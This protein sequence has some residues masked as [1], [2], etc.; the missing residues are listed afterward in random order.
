[1]TTKTISVNFDKDNIETII[2]LC[3]KNGLEFTLELLTLLLKNYKKVISIVKRFNKDTYE[4]KSERLVIGSIPKDDDIEVKNKAYDINTKKG[5]MP[6][7]NNFASLSFDGENKNK[8]CSKGGRNTGDTNILTSIK[9]R[10]ANGEVKDGMIDGIPVVENVIDNVMYCDKCGTMLKTFGYKDSI[11]IDFKPATL[12]FIY[13]RIAIKKCEYCES[14]INVERDEI[15]DKSLVTINYKANLIETKFSLGTPIYRLNKVKSKY[16][17]YDTELN[18]IMS[19]GEKLHPLAKE[20]EKAIFTKNSKMIFG[21]DETYFKVINPELLDG[22]KRMKNYVFALVSDEVTVYRFTGHR[23]IDW[24]I[25]LINITD[26]DGW[27]ITDKYNAYKILDIN[28]VL[29]YNQKIIK[30]NE[31]IKIKNKKIL[32]Y[33]KEHDK[34]HQKELIKEK[35]LLPIPKLKGRQL[36]LCHLRRLIYYAYLALPPILYDDDTST[37]YRLL[38]ALREIF[39]KEKK[40][41][42]LSKEERFKIRNSN[43]YQKLIDNFKAIIDS[44]EAEKGSYLDEAVK[45]ARNDWNSFWTYRKN[46]DLLISNQIVEN[47]IKTVS[48]L[49]KNSLNFNNPKTAVI[50]CDLLTIVTTAKQYG[51]NVYD[52][53]RYVLKY[54]DDEDIENLLPWSEKLYS[55]SLDF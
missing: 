39:M 37:P 1:M 13:T 34:N 15:T 36:C 2:D 16:L 4:T 28:Y 11:K 29:N 3:K 30:E 22:K 7:K 54:I 12:T 18:Y 40:L 8:E 6:P 43:E 53:I 49:R 51:L 21:V 42:K 50:N 31:E 19:C 32:E 5:I 35:D 55:R 47:K 46:G 23:H 17:N 14:L 9:D 38:I 52:Y 48:M 10:I 44:V 24:L 26:F 20:F 27:S 33:N 41:K 25:D 45:Y